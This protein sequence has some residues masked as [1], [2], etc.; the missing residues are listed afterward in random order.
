MQKVVP[1]AISRA[2]QMSILEVPGLEDQQET[3]LL[4]FLYVLYPLELAEKRIREKRTR[5]VPPQVI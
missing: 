3:R 4:R 1:I 5:D 2:S